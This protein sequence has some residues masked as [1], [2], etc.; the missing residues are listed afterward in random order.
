MG[1]LSKEMETVRVNLKKG[2]K[3]YPKLKQGK[4]KAIKKI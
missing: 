4:N 1:N 3:N 2:N